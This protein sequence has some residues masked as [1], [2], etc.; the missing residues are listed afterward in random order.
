[1]PTRL[2]MNGS[3]NEEVD[4]EVS[5]DA[6]NVPQPPRGYP[7]DDISA[8]S[9]Y[10]DTSEPYTITLSSHPPIH[11]HDARK[12]PPNWNA[13]VSLR[14][15]RKVRLHHLTYNERIGDLTL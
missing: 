8:A 15:E 1:V 4:V 3:K 13:H 10:Q 6:Y 14:G 11:P 2:E 12:M 7:V 9:A 5:P